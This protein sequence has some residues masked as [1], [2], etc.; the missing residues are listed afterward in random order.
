MSYPNLQFDSLYA[1]WAEDLRYLLQT[2]SPAAA[3]T[4]KVHTQADTGFA[5]PLLTAT[6]T[7]DDYGDLRG[8]V[9]PDQDAFGGVLGTYVLRASVSNGS[10][11]TVHYTK[12]FAISRINVYLQLLDG[13]LMALRRVPRRDMGETSPDLTA[14]RFGWANWRSDVVHQLFNGEGDEI[15]RDL[16]KFDLTAGKAFAVDTFEET[17]EYRGHYTFAYLTDADIYTYLRRALHQLNAKP[18]GTAYTL[19]SAPV[20]WESGLVMGAYIFALQRFMLDLNTFVYRR[21]FEDPTAMQATVQSMLAMAREQ[22]TEIESGLKRRGILSP[23]VVRSFDQARI[24]S[25]VDG[26]NYRQYSIL[27]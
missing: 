6:G 12:E 4:L 19:D 18:P 1:Y 3:V 17:V 15:T 2:G 10:D 23:A 22:Y 26:V 20:G 16:A 8:V 5:S 14:V 13:V 7:T 25:T 11:P 27:G 24:P 21:L 9:T